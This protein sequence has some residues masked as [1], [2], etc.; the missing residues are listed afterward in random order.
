MSVLRR[1]PLVCADLSEASNGYEDQQP[2]LG[3]EFFR[4]FF[5]HYRHLDRNAQFYA[6]RFAD[7]RRLNLDRLGQPGGTRTPIA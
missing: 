2:G 4:D 5:S 1:H 7:V 3:L 6:I